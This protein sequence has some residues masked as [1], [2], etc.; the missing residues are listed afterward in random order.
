MKKT[1]AHMPLFVRDY[2]MATRHLSLSERG[3]YMDLL[4]FQ[5]E[6][7]PLPADAHRLA[8]M[9]SCS[10]EDFNLAWIAIRTKFVE[11]T[12]DSLINERLEEHRAKALEL[13]AKRAKVGKKGGKQ[14]GKQRAKQKRSK[15]EAIAS[16]IALA[17]S[18][19]P[20]PSP[21]PI[22]EEL[23]ACERGGL[24]EGGRS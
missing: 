5:W 4:C 22:P 9:V 13:S 2:V 16:P 3:L 19:S 21:S 1:L 20:S 15:S 12:A 10:L 24:S 23:G 11:F 14:S 7:G 18:N 6:I 17:K 8:L